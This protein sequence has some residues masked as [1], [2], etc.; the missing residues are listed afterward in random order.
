MLNNKSLL[1]VLPALKGLVNKIQRQYE[2]IVIVL[3]IDGERGYG[4]ELYK[5]T[6]QVDIRVE[7]RALDTPEQLGLVE[8]ASYVIITKVRS[9]RIR[10]RL[11]KALSNE[12]ANIATRITNVTPIRALK[13]KTLYEI[14]LSKTLLLT[15]IAPIRCKAYVLNKKLKT[16]DKLE[17]RTF[18]SYLLRYN[19]TNIYRIQLLKKNRII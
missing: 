13:Q 2:H 5:I 8:K 14:I 10:A 1:L 18:I 16:V 7:L 11:P 3:K 19:S 9:L 12:L 4:L 6:K 15:Y 17:S